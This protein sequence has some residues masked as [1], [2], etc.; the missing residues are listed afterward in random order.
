M[1]ICSVCINHPGTSLDIPCNTSRRV[2]AQ[3]ER[4]EHVKQ[5]L[6]I[7]DCSRGFNISR[8]QFRKHSSK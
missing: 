4:G 3:G 7:L 2:R 8:Q 1:L 6:V 5:L